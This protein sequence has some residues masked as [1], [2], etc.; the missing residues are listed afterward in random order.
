M[1]ARNV[2]SYPRLYSAYQGIIGASAATR[3]MIRDHWGV[4][5][6]SR[7]LDFGCGVG[8]ALR[9]LPEGTEYLGIDLDHAYIERA[10]RVCH[11]RPA[12]SFRCGNV[13]DA[14]CRSAIG[15]FDVILAIGVF[16]H[17]AD[18]EAVEVLRCLANLCR[19]PESR[20]LCAEPCL[21]ARQDR[22]SRFIIRHDRG[23]FPRSDK[24]WADL[25]SP[26]FGRVD[27][28]VATGLYRIPFVSFLAECAQA[29][30]Y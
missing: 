14:G 27:G 1:N 16:H 4:G 26:A 2:L 8:S 25:F 19:G 12:A 15:R 17:M 10:R 24:A 3:W 20:L 11:S 30:Q 21:L 13:C 28:R 7:V 6:G 22:I 29:K 5:A 9:H 18:A 23:A